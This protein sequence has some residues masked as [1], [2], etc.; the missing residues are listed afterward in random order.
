MALG[1]GPEGGRFASGWANARAR[2][3]LDYFSKSPE[4]QVGAI[5]KLRA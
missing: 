4:Q 5:T 1:G 2:C 3:G